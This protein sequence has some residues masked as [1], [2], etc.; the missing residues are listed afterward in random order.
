MAFGQLEYIP[1][2]LNLT[3]Q[4]VKTFTGGSSPMQ[5]DSGAMSMAAQLMNSMAS[6]LRGTLPGSTPTTSTASMGN[7]L[8]IGGVATALILL[9]RKRRK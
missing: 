1:G 8:L 7:L 5:G 2:L 4:A 6:Q 3:G 9:L